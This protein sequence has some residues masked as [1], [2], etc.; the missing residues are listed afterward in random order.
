MHVLAADSHDIVSGFKRLAGLAE[1]IDTDSFCREERADAGDPAV[2]VHH[3]RFGGEIVIAVENR[4]AVVLAQG[5]HV[6]VAVNVVRGIFD[7][8]D[9]AIIIQLRNDFFTQPAAGQVRIVIEDQR[10]RKFGTD[11]LI[12]IVGFL[13]VRRNVPGCDDHDAVGPGFLRS[14][15]EQDRVGG[16]VRAGAGIDLAAMVHVFDGV[17]VDLQLL[18]QRH[19][20]K[21]AR[22]AAGDDTRRAVFDQ[23][24][25]QLVKR[26]IIDMFVLPA[27]GSHKREYNAAH[28]LFFHSRSPLWRVLE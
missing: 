18:L 5:T 7:G 15:G 9:D 24:V 22:A 10:N 19:G 23:K 1:V 6:L 20:Y 3:E 8:V 25:D 17:A 21:L 27:E 26:G 11:G 16:P 14:F 2:G 28:F 12:M 13:L 4:E